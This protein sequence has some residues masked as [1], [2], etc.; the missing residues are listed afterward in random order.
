MELME[1][2]SPH[3]FANATEKLARVVDKL[4][5]DFTARRSWSYSLFNGLLQG[6]GIAL[7][8]TLLFVVIFYGLIA[9]ESTPIIGD[10]ASRVIDQLFI[11]KELTQ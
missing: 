2:N 5:R 4:D 9:L 6:A 3:E 7:G 11:N 10:F 1:N 8:A